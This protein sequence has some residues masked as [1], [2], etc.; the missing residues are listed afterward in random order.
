M[1]SGPEKKTKNKTEKRASH[2]NTTFPG[3]NRV[4]KKM[5]SFHVSPN[6][7]G[8]FAK[9]L[10]FFTGSTLSS[11]S[12]AALRR[13]YNRCIGPSA[14]LD[15]QAARQIFTPTSIKCITAL[16]RLRG[17]PGWIVPHTLAQHAPMR[18]RTQTSWRRPIINCRKYA[19]YV[20]P[21]TL[22][23]VGENVPVEGRRR[24]E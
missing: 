7:L 20:G 13:F 10:Q 21:P 5:I 3:H 24:D 1:G 15:I 14:R 11:G 23:P 8:R 19:A 2:D 9:N 12:P 18:E 22:P 4:K 17:C 16:A 6:N